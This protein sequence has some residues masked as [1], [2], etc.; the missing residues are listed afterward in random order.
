MAKCVCSMNKLMCYF[1]KCNED[2]DTNAECV[3]IEIR[4]I[5]KQWTIKIIDCNTSSEIYHQRECHSIK[6]FL[7]VSSWINKKTFC[8]QELWLS[9][10]CN[11]I[12]IKIYQIIYR[13]LH[14]FQIDIKFIIFFRKSNILSIEPHW[15]WRC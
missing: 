15:I 10:N 12:Q 4:T 11:S 7:L 13:I 8:N 9:I 6:H 2:F 5:D 3:W 14:K 1:F